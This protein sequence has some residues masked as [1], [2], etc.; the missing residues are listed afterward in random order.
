MI[1][2]SVSQRKSTS[3][4]AIA[5]EAAK[6]PDRRRE[7]GPPRFAPNPALTG[8]IRARVETRHGRAPTPAQNNRTQSREIARAS[9]GCAAARWRGKRGRPRSRGPLARWPAR[10]RRTEVSASV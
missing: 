2:A 5:A 1:R 3:I 4:G 7:A 10:R 9:E 8:L 6:P